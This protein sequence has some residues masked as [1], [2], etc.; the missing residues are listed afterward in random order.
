MASWTFKDKKKNNKAETLFTPGWYEGI[1]RG[2]G[3]EVGSSVVCRKPNL[4]E[5]FICHSLNK[6]NF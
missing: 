4:T 1:E 3:G 5:P 6:M 2:G